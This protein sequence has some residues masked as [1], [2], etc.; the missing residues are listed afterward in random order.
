[1]EV[2]F[3][4]PFVLHGI[5]AFSAV[6][7]IIH[8]PL[9]DR[10]LLLAQ[11]DAHISSALSIYMRFLHQPSLEYALPMFFLSGILFAY[12][13]A[14][15]QINEPEDPIGDFLHC[16]RLLRGVREVVGQY[17]QELSKSSIVHEMLSGVTDIE[18]IP[19]PEDE[20]RMYEPLN[21]LKRFALSS[22]E[23]HGHVLAETVDNLRITFLKSKGCID[24][25]YEHSL[26]MTWWA[27]F[28]FDSTIDPVTGH[29]IF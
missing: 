16:L 17:W 29:T 21:K 15:A 25:R 20:D 18:G 19:V 4:H 8:H 3:D 9:L 27:H 13:L 1:M 24:E 2:A 23:H 10:T 26:F 7:K 22:K 11:A 5:L 12:N 28:P 6:H 14:S